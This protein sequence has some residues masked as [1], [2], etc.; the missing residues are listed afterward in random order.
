MRPGS[1]KNQ[2]VAVKP[3][4]KQ[5]VRFDMALAVFLAITRELVISMSGFQRLL[6]VELLNDRS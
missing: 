6:A 2:V 3:V 1:L 5:P 4:N